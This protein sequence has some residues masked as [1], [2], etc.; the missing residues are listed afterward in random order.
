MFPFLF[1]Y[2][3][4]LTYSFSFS[5]MC[6]YDDDTNRLCPLSFVFLSS[7]RRQYLQP[8]LP[9][10]KRNDHGRGGRNHD[11]SFFSLLSFFR[12]YVVYSPVFPNRLD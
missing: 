7:S 3:V 6:F 9:S 12:V 11:G 1:L 10:L 8:K 4:D 5:I 2:F